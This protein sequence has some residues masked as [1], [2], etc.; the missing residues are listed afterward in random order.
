MRYVSIL[1]SDRNLD[2]ELWAVIWQANAPED[3]ILHCAYNLAGNKRIFIW[4]SDSTAALQFMDNFNHI[5]LL[6]TYPAFDRSDGWRAAFVG[7][8]EAFRN[9]MIKTATDRGIVSEKLK[10]RV[11]ESIDLRQGALESPTR[12]AARRSAREWVAYREDANYGS[13]TK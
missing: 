1:T 11:K 6:E 3:L 13:S 5:G 9:Q 4:E 7:D 10:Q 8:I 12:E 2:P